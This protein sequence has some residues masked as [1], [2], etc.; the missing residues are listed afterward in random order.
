MEIDLPNTNQK[1]VLIIGAGFGG[2][3]LAKE[4]KNS[5]YQVVLIDKNNFHCFQPLMYQVATSRLDAESVIHPIRNIFRKQNN[6]SFRMAEIKEIV[7]QE[8][9]IRL[10]KRII[11]YDY[12]VIAT[13]AKT[14]YR[15]NEGLIISAMPMKSINEALELRSLILQNFENALLIKEVTVH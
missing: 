12:L 15:K 13:G 5:P 14:N 3:Q 1:R 2:I 6:F 7:P 10:G 9:K 8:N 11:S 4:L